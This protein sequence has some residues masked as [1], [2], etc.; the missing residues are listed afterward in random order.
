MPAPVSPHSFPDLSIEQQY[1]GYIAGID[2]AG[3]GPLAGPVVAACVI[4]DYD[5]IPPGLNDSKQL[6]AKKRES[7][8]PLILASATV[9]IGFGSLRDIDTHNILGATKL[10]MRR[11]LLRLPIMPDI[12]LVDGNQLPDLPCQAIGV[13]KGDSKSLSIAAASII[14]KVMRDRIMAK[15]AIKYPVYGWDSNA[16]YGTEQHCRAID[17]FGITRHHRLSFAPVRDRIN[18]DLALY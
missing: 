3:R 2:E 4:L 12:A 16:G 18:K 13:V 11:A 14:A 10:A 5:N 8:Y 9:G 15:L 1:S 7:L 17:D 6:T